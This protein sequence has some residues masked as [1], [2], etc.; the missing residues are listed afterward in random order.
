MELASK[1]ATMAT[2]GIADIG[3]LIDGAS[4]GDV[5]TDVAT[6]QGL[7]AGVA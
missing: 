6:R 2:G 7:A 5:A 1:A 4:W 3:S